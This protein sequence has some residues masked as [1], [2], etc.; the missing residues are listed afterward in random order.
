MNLN[1]FHRR[2]LL[3]QG[4]SGIGSGNFQGIGPLDVDL[5][6]RNPTWLQKADLIFVVRLGGD[7]YV[8]VFMILIYSVMLMLM[9]ML[10]YSVMKIENGGRTT[11]W[12]LGTAT[13]RTRVR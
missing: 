8:S 11:R 5:K 4:E 10:I 9:L 1:S 12:A 6:P 13:W 2:P 3:D 7:L